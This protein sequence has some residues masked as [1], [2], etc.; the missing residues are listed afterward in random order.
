MFFKFS[1]E[2][3]NEEDLYIKIIIT[4]RGNEFE[5]TLFDHFC[6]KKVHVFFP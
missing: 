4:F 6:S 5:N 2:S 3:Y 1:Y